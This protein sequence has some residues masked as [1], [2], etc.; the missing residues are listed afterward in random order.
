MIAKLRRR[1]AGREGFTLIEVLIAMVILAVGLLALESMGIGAARLVARA[2]RESEYTAL[3]T[4]E[5]EAALSRFRATGAVAPGT[6]DVG[7]Y[8]IAIART[9]LPAVV[10]SPVL[11]VSSVEVSVTVSPRVG[12]DPLKFKPV[13]VVGRATRP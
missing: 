13:T 9:I 10:V 12:T 7:V 3:A 2:D 6:R 1:P 4:A 11:T 5:L 8:N